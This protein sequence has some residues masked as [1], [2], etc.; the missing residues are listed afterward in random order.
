[1]TVDRREMLD[2]TAHDSLF[3]RLSISYIGAGYTAMEPFCL[4]WPRSAL[5]SQ[6][7]E[8]QLVTPLRAHVCE[9]LHADGLEPRE[10]QL[11]QAALVHVGKP[12]TVAQPLVRSV[13]ERTVE[14]SPV[15]QGARVP[16][17]AAAP[18]EHARPGGQ[19]GRECIQGLVHAR[20][21]GRAFVY[22]Q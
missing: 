9:A 6:A 3:D 17:A 15:A 18:V 8:P 19:Q 2:P 11:G 5:A 7:V 21:Y 10:K 14:H 12:T 4:P 16:P 1:M 13:L 20:A 22:G